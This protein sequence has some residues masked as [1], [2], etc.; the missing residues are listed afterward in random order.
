MSARWFQSFAIG[1]ILTSG[2][3][4]S[5]ASGQPLDSTDEEGEVVG[6][7][8]IVE[9]LNR[10]VNHSDATTMKAHQPK[11]PSEDPFE[12]VWM[13]A[14]AGF[15]QNTQSVS[16]PE[17][18]TAYLNQKGVQASLGIDLFSPNWAAEGTVRSFND[19]DDKT[20]QV[21]LKEFELKAFYKDRFTRS[22]GF[23]VGGGISGRYMTISRAG[24]ASLD[25]TTPS[26]VG[27]VGIDL[28]LSDRFSLGVEASGRSAMISDTLDR[29]SL[30]GTVRLDAHF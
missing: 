25:S 28:F 19:N 20:T 10:Q 12:N 6:Y 24:L 21:S 15:V 4:V 5:L 22:M 26:S 23:R 11:A 29:G 8:V 16:L 9:S 2:F 30:D 7:D 18:N 14:G 13:H 17:G 1:L 27:T 3:G